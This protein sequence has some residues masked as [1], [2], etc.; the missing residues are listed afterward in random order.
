ML[1]VKQRQFVPSGP[2][3]EDCDIHCVVESPVPTYLL[4]KSPAFLGVAKGD[5]KHSLL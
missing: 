5:I 4:Y 2:S 1:I 3:K